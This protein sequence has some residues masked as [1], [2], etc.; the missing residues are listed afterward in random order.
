MCHARQLTACP[1]IPSPVRVGSKLSHISPGFMA[2]NCKGVRGGLCDAMML[3]HVS[4]SS[5]EW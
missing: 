4:P 3:L 5:T 1:P 2:K